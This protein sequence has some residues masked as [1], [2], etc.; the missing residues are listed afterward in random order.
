MFDVPATSEFFKQN[1]N[2]KCKICDGYIRKKDSYSYVFTCSNEFVN[3]ATWDTQIYQAYRIDNDAIW[4]YEDHI[5]VSKN[6][7]A[8]RIDRNFAPQPTSIEE[9]RK[10]INNISLLM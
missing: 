2:H 1:V 9:L 10:L 4:F 6:R 8:T 5:L 3:H 7:H